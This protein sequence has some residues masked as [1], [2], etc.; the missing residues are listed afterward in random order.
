MKTNKV[1]FREKPWCPAA[2]LRGR[3]M[4]VASGEAAG[5]RR[6]AAGGRQAAAAA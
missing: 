3:D 5:S 4:R 1:C 2:R 6:D